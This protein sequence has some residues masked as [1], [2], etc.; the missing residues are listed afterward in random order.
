MKT[1]TSGEGNENQARRH[2]AAP[3]AQSDRSADS[4]VCVFRNRDSREQG[5]PRPKQGL[6]D[7]AP[8]STDSDDSPQMDRPAFHAIRF[9]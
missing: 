6:R 4:F 7:G 2:K 8:G 3:S 1:G 5:C 9:S